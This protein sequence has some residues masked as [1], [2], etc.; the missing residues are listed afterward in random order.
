MTRADQIFES[1]VKFHKANPAVWVKFQEFA[2]VILLANFEHYSADAICHRIRWH[3]ATEHQSD[4][5]INDHYTALY[6]R[7]FEL[8]YP[9]CTGFF[10]KRHRPSKH[11][12]ER[13]EGFESGQNADEQ[14]DEAMR[15]QLLKLI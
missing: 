1:F 14:I 10:R 4:F 5:K 13:G 3:H 12:T 8:A 15:E 2:K 7:M 6:A 9:E 11:K